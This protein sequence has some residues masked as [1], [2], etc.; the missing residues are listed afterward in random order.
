M[1]CIV[2]CLASPP[3][4]RPRWGLC[5]R[6][7]GPLLLPSDVSLSVLWVTLEVVTVWQDK[8]P[9]RPS[10]DA[11]LEFTWEHVLPGGLRAAA[12]GQGG[13]GHGHALG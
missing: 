2:V 7:E 5:I 3:K 8:G 4:V 12:G 10:P 1:L 13:E 6:A 9:A 11:T